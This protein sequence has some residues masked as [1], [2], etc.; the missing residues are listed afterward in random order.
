MTMRTQK[1][2][3]SPPN[4]DSP[5]LGIARFTCKGLVSFPL[6][7]AFNIVRLGRTEIVFKCN[8]H[9]AV[10]V[11]TRLCTMVQYRKMHC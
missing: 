4:E 3:Q 7:G 6:M 11:G 5:K 9:W 2:V 10:E 8:E 1:Y